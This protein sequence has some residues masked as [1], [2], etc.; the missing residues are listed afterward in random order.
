MPDPPCT[1]TYLWT[2]TSTRI[3]LANF[4][5]DTVDVCGGK[6]ASASEGAETVQLDFTPSGQGA[7]D[8]VTINV[9]VAIIRFAESNLQGYGFDDMDNPAGA[10]PH[11]SVRKSDKSWVHVAVEGGV[12]GDRFNYICDDKNVAAGGAGAASPGFHLSVTAGGY[13]TVETIL[14][15]QCKCDDHPDFSGIYVNVY[16]QKPVVA[17]VAKV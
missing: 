14:R 13:D 2:T 9:T 6:T 11:L 16:K 10:L 12:N 15:A 7:L 1:G 17:T 8:P 4:H 5:A 3:A